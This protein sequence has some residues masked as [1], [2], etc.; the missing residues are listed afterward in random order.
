MF[1]S[2]LGLRAWMK[3][4]RAWAASLGRL[5]DEA[6]PFIE[7]VRSLA[8]EAFRLAREAGSLAA[9]VLTLSREPKGSLAKVRNW[10]EAGSG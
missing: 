7:E 4:L 10:R 2:A 6:I 3:S 9:G 8:P 1:D 5:M